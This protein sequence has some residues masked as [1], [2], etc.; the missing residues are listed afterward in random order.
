MLY[1]AVLYWW[2]VEYGPMWLF[3]D[4]FF[5]AKNGEDVMQFALAGMMQPG[6]QNIEVWK[7]VV[8]MAR[9]RLVPKPD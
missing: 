5:R 7:N 4:A 8:E 6:N 3:D 9:Q 1:A 2:K